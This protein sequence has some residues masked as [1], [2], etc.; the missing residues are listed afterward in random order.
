MI[1]YFV[2]AAEALIAAYVLNHLCNIHKRSFFVLTAIVTFIMEY[3]GDMLALND[4]PLLFAYI[5]SWMILVLIFNRKDILK[6]FFMVLANNLIID[7]GAIIAILLFMN[8]NLTLMM[9]VAKVIQLILSVLFHHIDHLL[10]SRIPLLS[11]REEHLDI[12][13]GDSGQTSGTKSLFSLGVREMTTLVRV[14][15]I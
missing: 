8:V 4:L 6:N 3:L 9:I 15:S 2:N 5:T 7:V 14:S 11:G 12:L 10:D 13:G 1:S